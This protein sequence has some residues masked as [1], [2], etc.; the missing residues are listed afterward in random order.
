MTS[1]FLKDI[2]AKISQQLTG[3]QSTAQDIAAKI[4]KQLTDNASSTRNGNYS[5]TGTGT[6][7]DHITI[8]NVCTPSHVEEFEINDSPV[9]GHESRNDYLMYFFGEKSHFF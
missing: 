6:A 4:T 1:T 8:L 7:Q 3:N 5:G 9:S 2:A